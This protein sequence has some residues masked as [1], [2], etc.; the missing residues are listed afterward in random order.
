VLSFLNTRKYPTFKSC[1]LTNSDHP[2][3]MTI[4]PF[5]IF[6]STSQMQPQ[7]TF[8]L[9]FS[10]HSPS[11]QCTKPLG[12][13]RTSDPAESNSNLQKLSAVFS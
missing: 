11:K 10:E 5:S 9:I 2:P 3:S 4:F 12:M 7:E 8:S 13:A 1:A 6:R